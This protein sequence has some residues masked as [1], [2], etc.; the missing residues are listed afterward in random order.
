VQVP[1][2]RPDEA[3]VALAAADPIFDR[4][5]EQ[6]QPH[7]GKNAARPAHHVHQRQLLQ[8]SGAGSPTK[9]VAVV[10]RISGYDSSDAA[11]AASNLLSTVVRNGSLASTLAAQG[12][13]GASVGLL[14][15]N[16]GSVG[17]LWDQA[18]FVTRLAIAV[19]CGVA[20]GVAALAAIW[21]IRRRRR[22]GA[23]RMPH[24]QQQ[25]PGGPSVVGPRASSAM[26]P[27]AARMSAAALYLPP[28]QAA[29]RVSTVEG[30]LVYPAPQP[31]GGGG[32]YS[33]SASPSAPMLLTPHQQAA[34]AA[35]Q[36]AG[37]PLGQR[38]LQQMRLQAGSPQGGRSSIAAAMPGYPVVFVA[39]AGPG[40]SLA[41]PPGAA[42]QPG[43]HFM[44]QQHAAMPVH[45]APGRYPS[46]SPPPPQQ[47][48][49]Q[50]QQ[51]AAAAAPGPWQV[52]QQW[53]QQ[54]QHR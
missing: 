32:A 44:L 45:P 27:G 38:Q 23:A 13:P 11:A 1:L 15:V 52:Q 16:T 53:Q 26:Q 8:A 40:A 37:S 39:P 17:G 12:W 19:S 47:Q 28:Q 14:Y 4:Q 30:V 25:G 51:W 2:P 35:R 20:G 7:D 10:M 41:G 18:S 31:G 33:R 5:Q 43:R 3:L 50:Q 22:A 48:Q 24:Q 29:G 21:C 46:M 42:V 54:Q 34:L 49:Q 6:A 36:G 9:G